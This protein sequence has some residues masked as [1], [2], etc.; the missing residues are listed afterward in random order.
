MLFH[1]F[2]LNFNKKNLF[3]LF[4]ESKAKVP[5]IYGSTTSVTYEAPVQNLPDI[6][7]SVLPHN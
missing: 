5:I 1:S 4:S 2:K 3:S 7:Q 6:H